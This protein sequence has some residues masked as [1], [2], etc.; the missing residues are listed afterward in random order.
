MIG[1][2]LSKLIK[3]EISVEVDFTIHQAER[4]SYDDACENLN[5]L[6]LKL[7]IKVNEFYLADAITCGKRDCLV[8]SIRK[9]ID[10]AKFFIKTMVFGIEE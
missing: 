6:G 4:L 3:D 2:D 8:L 1:E 9:R 10:D 7:S 5:N